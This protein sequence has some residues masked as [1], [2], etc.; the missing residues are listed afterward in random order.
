MTLAGLISNTANG[1]NQ[2][3]PGNSSPVL[4][5]QVC[6]DPTCTV[7]APAGANPDMFSMQIT[8]QSPITSDIILG[9]NPL[10][11]IQFVNGS[12]V[13]FQE[14]ESAV[15][16]NSAFDYIPGINLGATAATRYVYNGAAVTAPFDAI[17]VSNINNTQP[18]TGTVIIQDVNGNTIVSATLPAIPAGGAAGYLL[19]GRFPGDTLGLFPSSTA[20]PEADPMGIFHGNLVVSTVGQTT[21]GFTTVLAQEYNGDSML[22]LPVLH[23]AVQ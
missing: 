5:T 19:I 20:L 9:P 8:A 23:G 16:T 3:Y 13:T 6:W 22:N 14:T 4:V 17:S 18:I 12:Q 10:L 15:R 21:N 1:A 2:I 7:A 11:T